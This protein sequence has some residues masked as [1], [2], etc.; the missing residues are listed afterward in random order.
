MLAD[1]PI[2]LGA[3]IGNYPLTQRKRAC[4]RE[5]GTQVPTNNVMH[6]QPS[7]FTGYALHPST[8]STANFAPDFCA[9]RDFSVFRFC[10]THASAPYLTY[11][12]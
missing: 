3:R 1:E 4:L 2:M 6:F 11:D 5:D 10:R 8:L 9:G 12:S 7:R